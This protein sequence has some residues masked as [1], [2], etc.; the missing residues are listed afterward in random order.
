M[1]IPLEWNGGIEI[2]SR[3]VKTILFEFLEKKTSTILSLSLDGIDAPCVYFQWIF[4]FGVAHHD[5][6]QEPEEENR[7]RGR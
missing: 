4:L 7:R 5:H 3:V 1:G 2:L 6:V